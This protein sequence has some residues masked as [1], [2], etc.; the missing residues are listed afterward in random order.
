MIADHD[1]GI[2]ALVSRKDVLVLM[3][4]RLHFASRGQERVAHEVEVLGAHISIVEPRDDERRSLD[5]R[6]AG[7]PIARRP[8]WTVITRKLRLGIPHEGAISL[9]DVQHSRIGFVEQA[10]RT[11]I[12]KHC[13]VV[14]S[15][16]GKCADAL[17]V[18]G[19]VPARRP[20][21]GHN[22]IKPFDARRGHFEAHGARIG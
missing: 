11:D 2:V 9:V 16:G 20:R 8:I 17:A 5:A 7:I 13:R 18:L 12:G 14:V 1:I 6:L 19:I 10:A 4:Q 3:Q 15:H 22:R 21:H